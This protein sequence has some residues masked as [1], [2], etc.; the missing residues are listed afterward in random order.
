[1]N[2]NPTTR[3]GFVA[4]TLAL[5]GPVAATAG[6]SGR[7][8]EPSASPATP[9]RVLCVGGHPDDPE[10]SCAGTL[11]LYV[12][13]GHAVTVIYLTRG[14]RGIQGAGLEEAARIR[15]A[16]AEAACRILGAKARFFGQVDG[17]TEFTRN[18]VEG[19]TRLFHEE[20]PDVVFTHWPIDSH[21]DHQVAS[22]LTQRA[23]LNV[24]NPPALF[25]FEV[26]TGSQSRGFQPNTY[27]DVTS[28]LS[29]KKAA[30]VA[31]RSQDGEGVWQEHHDPIA[32][33]RG[34]EIGVEAAEAF[35]RLNAKGGWGHP[36]GLG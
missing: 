17:A 15:S 25:L 19:M 16:E 12:D 3:R 34:R 26:N 24:P 9:L 10:S 1:M 5:A 13:R 23:C 35:L 7:A 4:Q 11:A 8:A 29:R 31:H 20:R 27:V 30:L 22:F 2:D 36:P 21:M 33:W 28:V 18:H 32:R 6:L 14:E